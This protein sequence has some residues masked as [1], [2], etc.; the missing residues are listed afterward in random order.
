MF[1]H[2]SRIL[3]RYLFQIFGPLLNFQKFGN[4]SCFFLF[5]LGKKKTLGK[6][7]KV[8]RYVRAAIIPST[9]ALYRNLKLTLPQSQTLCSHSGSACSP[10]ARKLYST[11]GTAGT[12]YSTVVAPRSS[13]TGRPARGY[14]VSPPS[15][16]T[17]EN[18]QQE[19]LAEIDWQEEWENSAVVIVKLALA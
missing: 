18:E 19:G 16:L 17:Q 13:S 9:P 4:I 15:H 12:R 8:G 14:S 7:G 6:S 5:S 11:A 10:A 3:E 1:L 2:F